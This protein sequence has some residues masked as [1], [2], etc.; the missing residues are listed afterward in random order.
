MAVQN[1]TRATS[2]ASDSPDENGYESV[3]VS[4]LQ[5]GAELKRPV[6]D[7]RNVLL[8]AGGTQVTPGF[9]SRL[10]RRNVATVKIHS[11][12]VDWLCAGRARGSAE[13]VPPDRA[14]YYCPERNDFSDAL[15]EIVF[16]NRTLQ[17]SP[18]KTRLCELPERGAPVD[19]NSVVRNECICWYVSAVDRLYNLFLRMQ[20]APIDCVEPV[21]QLADEMLEKVC[22]Y[23]EI[24]NSLAANPRS[25]KYPARH[26]IHAAMLAVSLGIRSGLDAEEMHWLAL[27]TLL[28][29]AGM[30][31]IPAR[32]LK[33]EKTWVESTGAAM[34]RHPI[35]TFD[36]I[37]DR[38][39]LPE[40]AA[41]VIYQMHERCNGQ[42]YPRRRESP[43]IHPLAR[44][45]AVADTYVALA[46][47]RPHRD[48][49]L[50]YRIAE[51]MVRSANRGLFDPAAVRALLQ[52]V[53]LF[54]V[55]SFV[56]LSNGRRGRVV[57]TN[58]DSFERPVVEVAC[59]LADL[60]NDAPLTP[61]Y[62]DL[63]ANPDIKVVRPLAD[64][65]VE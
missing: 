45:A 44:I 25:D 53:S 5:I 13:V 41:F 38:E 49:I 51:H 6:Y 22:Q 50:P 57:Q 63:Q 23:H 56:E 26:A 55:G 9:I 60:P 35:L 59:N 19:A 33:T 21:S 12:E 37:V 34:T 52:T 62:L 3:R 54:P 43:Q 30:L 15:D 36:L 16:K 1:P 40:A 65:A 28:H 29:D 64:L 18:K 61:E 8:I 58:P 11:S 10:Q 46:D 2:V 17:R 42:G 32:L 24:W 4:G 27:G 47:K 20:R 39:Q 14:G 31:L 48:A 7:D